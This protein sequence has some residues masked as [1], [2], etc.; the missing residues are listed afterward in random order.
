MPDIAQIEADLAAARAALTRLNTGTLQV[1]VEYDGRRVKFAAASATRLEA[2]VRSLE[3]QLARAAGGTA[4]RRRS[5]ARV[6]F[7]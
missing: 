2:H 7:G 6:T 3:D 1:E 4:G 5:S